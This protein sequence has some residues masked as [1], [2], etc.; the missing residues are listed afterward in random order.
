VAQ[1]SEIETAVSVDGRRHTDNEGIGRGKILDL[2]RIVNDRAAQGRNIGLT[3]PVMPG[4]GI[5]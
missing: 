2:G 3:G 4:T 5:P 1:E